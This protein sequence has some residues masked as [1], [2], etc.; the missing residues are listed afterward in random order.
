MKFFAVTFLLATP[1]RA[2]TFQR[3]TVSLSPLLTTTTKTTS[4][5]RKQY[6][7]NVQMTT[8]SLA[9]QESVVVT[10]DIAAALVSPPST[11][12]PLANPK[13]VPVILEIDQDRR[14][15]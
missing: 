14:G 3:R 10:P 12:A 8:P 5:Q 4:Q 13:A 15:R 11:L 2:F 9:E 7:L 6:G 1:T